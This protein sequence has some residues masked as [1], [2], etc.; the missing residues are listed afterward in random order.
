MTSSCLHQQQ[1]NPRSSPDLWRPIHQTNDGSP[2]Y[3]LGTNI[4]K[5]FDG[6]QYKG[7]IISYDADASLYKTSYEDNDEEE[8]CHIEVK[9]HL[10]P[11]PK[12]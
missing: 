4:Y 2:R 6:I 10:H 11:I 8:M 1:P 9:A 3:K 7:K 5:L 12:S